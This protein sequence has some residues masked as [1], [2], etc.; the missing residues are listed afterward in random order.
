M[1][2]FGVLAFTSLFAVLN[3]IGVIPAYIAIT[4]ELTPSQKQVVLRK[5][6]VTAWVTLTAFAISGD[7]VFSFFDVTV[8]SLRVVGGIILFRIGYDMLL[9]RFTTS[10]FQ[11]E[12]ASE[13][14]SDI[15]ITPLA[16]PIIAGPGSIATSIILFQES[17]NIDERIVTLLAILAVMLATFLILQSGQRILNLLGQSGNT[18]VIRLMGLMLMVIAVEIFFAGVEPFI[19]RIFQ[20]S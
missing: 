8:D 1:F 10:Q 4:R 6:S 16:I 5:A 13:F 15:A 18:V 7:L 11:D 14:I 19:V 17:A 12:T 3:P 2:D 20:I 9:D